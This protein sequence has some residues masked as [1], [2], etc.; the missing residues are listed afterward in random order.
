MDVIIQPESGTCSKAFL[1]QK[2]TCFVY[3]F[4][5]VCFSVTPNL[6][7][8]CPAAVIPSFCPKIV[9]IWSWKPSW[10]LCCQELSDLVH[11]CWSTMIL[12]IIRMAYGM[13]AD[14]VMNSWR[15]MMFAYKLRFRVV[16]FQRGWT[17]KLAEFFEYRQSRKAVL[18]KI[19][20]DVFCETNLE[21]LGRSWCCGRTCV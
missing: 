16:N 6:R 10:T 13:V 11:L 1:N 3:L 12:R 4:M 14:D 7:T 15:E 8:T 2:L 9:T 5:F 18:W 20:Q 19:L 17:H 21:C